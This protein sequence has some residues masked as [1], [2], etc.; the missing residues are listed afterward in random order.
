MSSEGSSLRTRDTLGDVTLIMMVLKFPRSKKVLF[1]STPNVL[2][3]RICTKSNHSQS[4]ECQLNILGL[5]KTSWKFCHTINIL[6]IHYKNMI[7]NIPTSISLV[8]LATGMR[9]PLLWVR[10][11]APTVPLMDCAL[12]QENGFVS[13]VII[14][15]GQQIKCLWQGR[16]QDTTDFIANKSARC[17]I[18]ELKWHNPKNCICTPFRQHTAH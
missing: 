2:G 15:Y 11:S 18:T 17:S 1:T 10:D 5:K 16:I 9:E 7:V 4:T 3:K 14:W 12:F 13:K 8:K 6:K